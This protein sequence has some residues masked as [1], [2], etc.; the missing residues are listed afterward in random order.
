M[1]E[2]KTLTEEEFKARSRRSFL[3]GIAGVAAGYGGW[4]Y[5]QGDE[6]VDRIPGV[7]RSMHERNA[8]IW[9]TLYDGDRLAKTFDPSRAEPLR[10]N[11]RHGAEDEIDLEQWS[12]D[13]VGRS[14]EMIGSHR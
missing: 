4:R 7:L 1:S 8:D 5:I 12:M 3:T 14:G 9:Q 13:I 10:F 11:G 2:R 6:P